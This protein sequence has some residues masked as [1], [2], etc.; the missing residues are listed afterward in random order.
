MAI[1]LDEKRRMVEDI[2]DLAQRAVSIV[3]A[4]HCGLTVSELTVL[5]A[6][7]REQN[8]HLQVVRNRLAK[9]ALEGSRFESLVPSLS[10]PTLLACSF[11]APGVA[12]RIL[13]AF[14][15]QH[16]K[17]NVK[18]ISLGDGSLSSD[19]LNFVASMPTRDEGLAQVAMMLQSPIR[20]L[21]LSIKD[22]QGRLVRTLAALSAARAST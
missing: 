14:M 6:Q 1:F 19:Q 11:E 13:K 2:S 17:L 10:G 20:S 18:M 3:V 5:R 8:V 16:K 22:V 12:A 21:A 7:A 15:K 4:D 9:R